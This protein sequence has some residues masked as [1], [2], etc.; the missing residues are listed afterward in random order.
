MK[1]IIKKLK[2]SVRF[3]KEKD[4]DLIERL[5]Q[6]QALSHR[7]AHYFEKLLSNYSWYKE[8]SLAVDIEY[9]KNIDSEKVLP[10]E[11]CKFCDGIICGGTKCYIKEKN[12]KGE[13]LLPKK[14]RPDISLHKR[15]T[16][17]KNI[18]VVEIKKEKKR[19]KKD[20]AKLS[21][22]TCYKNVYKYEIGVYI[23]IEKDDKPE[24]VFFYKGV[25]TKEKDLS[26]KKIE[27]ILKLNSETR[28]QT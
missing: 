3:L 16:H 18:L 4:S 9:N 11:K 17:D 13:K 7:I 22:L 26:L 15:G 1:K 23:D 14:C 24:Y 27:D 5:V 10:K 8:S 20:F 6:E 21:I 19:D 2:K 25:K 12:C 28:I